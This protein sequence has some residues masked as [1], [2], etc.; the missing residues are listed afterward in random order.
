MTND[1]RNELQELKGFSSQDLDR[2]LAF[3][4]AYPEPGEFSPQD[5]AKSLDAAPTAGM[6][7]LV[8]VQ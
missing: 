6:T 8:V 5:V 1:L 2:M 7:P 3:V 4:R